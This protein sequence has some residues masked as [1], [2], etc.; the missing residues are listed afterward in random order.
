DMRLLKT[1]VLAFAYSSNLLNGIAR[2]SVNFLL[3]FYLQGIKSM[4][5]I[6]AGI[7]LSPFAAA[8]LIIAPISGWLSD[9]YGSRVL[10]SV[11]LLISAFG[12]IGFIFITPETSLIE[13]AVW[14]IIMG[15]GSG[16]FFSPNTN[17]IMSA[18]PVERRGI[19]AGV[20]TMMNNAGS[21]ISI[22]LAMAIISTT[23]TP[24]ALQGLFAGTQVG[25]QG[26]AVKEFIGGLRTAFIISF[27]FSLLAAVIS[28]LRGP[29][30]VWNS[31]SD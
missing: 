30:P 29:Q 4:D 27:I 20:R 7:M 31:E 26:I 18:V 3:V 5:P 11:G 6:I 17:A 2:G 28:Y 22:G 23:V 24:E 21:V 10:S 13:L 8:M 16:M 25:S 15:V 9:K 1:R 12:L 19:A 14:M